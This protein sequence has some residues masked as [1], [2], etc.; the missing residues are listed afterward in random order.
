MCHQQ[1]ELA[2][3]VTRT[4]DD[5]RCM[6]SRSFCHARQSSERMD[7]L[8]CFTRQMISQ[9]NLIRQCDVYRKLLPAGL[10]HSKDKS[11]HIWIHGL[12]AMHWIQDLYR[13]KHFQLGDNE[14]YRFKCNK[15][16]PLVNPKKWKSGKMT[17]LK[18]SCPN[19]GRTVNRGMKG[20]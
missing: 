16:V 8:T 9:T 5:K 18:A 12:E 4:P 19:C 20:K 2:N 3:T 7:C 15:V 6:Q 14:A 11:E 17:L 1:N 10:P 13:G